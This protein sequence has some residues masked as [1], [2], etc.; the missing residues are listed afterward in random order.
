MHT[1]FGHLT[2][3]TNIHSGETWTDHFTQLKKYIPGIKKAI[4]PRHPFGIGLR[5]SNT[6][7]IELQDKK[8][9]SNFKQWLKEEDC[10]VFTMNGFPYGSFHN[11][12]VK[13]QVHAPDWTTSER[14]Q[15]TIR[16]AKILADLLPGNM[17]GG[18]ST[19]PL[20]YRFWHNASNTSSVFE[21]ATLHVLQVVGEMIQIK[22]STG[23]VL[24][25]DIEPEPDGL[26]ET[27]DDFFTWYLNYLLPLG[28]VYLRERFEYS[29]NEA[30]QAIKEHVQL[31]YDI[32]HFSI[33]YENPEKVLQKALTHGI[34][35]GKIQISAALKASLVNN[36]SRDDVIEAF[37]K[38]NE[39]TYLHQVIASQNDGRLQRFPDVPDALEKANDLSIVE[40][41]A[42][43]HVPVF[44]EN[45]GILQS[46][47]C[48]IVEVLRKQKERP[49]SAHMEVET[50]TW[51][52]LPPELKMPLSPSIIRELEWV[53]D[54]LN[55][56]L[57]LV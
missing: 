19:S 18:I 11:T 16:L 29:E 12:E 40:W 6:A 56:E 26:L 7:S 34:R 35:I 33:G 9:L 5:L 54:F 21:T 14:V 1:P 45:Y 13:D 49:F 57:K 36:D 30:E 52:V 47:Q 32:C 38:F 41:R 51:E 27:G 22:K 39:P 8:I 53:L 20:S 17:E 2:Y 28:I 48:D 3:C 25:L 44:I 4:S 23:K 15:Y 24:H 55:R 37:K 43:F 31:C 50:Y 10:Y 42:H 46:T